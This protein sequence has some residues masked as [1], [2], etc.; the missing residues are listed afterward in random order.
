MHA[1]AVGITA[2][3]IPLGWVSV[4]T[5]GHTKRITVNAIML[6]AYS[7]GNG[8]G[9]FLWQAKYAPRWVLSRLTL[10]IRPNSW[11][12]RNHIPWLVIGICWV[13]SA[14]LLQYI[15]HHLSSENK[16]RNAETPDDM[17]NEVYIEYRSEEGKCMKRRVDK[18]CC[19]SICSDFYAGEVG[20]QWVSPGIFGSYRYPKS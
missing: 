10:A 4:V 15:R 11:E 16:R 13:S 17:Y 1:L 9:P 18:V 12:F 20:L 14:A 3:L 8:T 6:S 2:F 19:C 5:S 7:I